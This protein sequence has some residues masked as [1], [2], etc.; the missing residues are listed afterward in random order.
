MALPLPLPRYEI[1][2]LYVED[3][4]STREQI[5]RMLEHIV[6]ELYVAG[7]GQ[8]GLEQFREHSPDVVLTDIRMPVMNG[9]DMIREIN[10]IDPDCQVI[11]LTDF[12]VTEYLLE[13]I[14]LG[15]NQFLKNPY[16]FPQLAQAIGQCND[17]I[18]LKRHLAR[19]GDLVHLLS[20]AMEQA[21]VLVMITN[22]D[23]II[24]YVNSTFVRVTGYEASE[25]IGQN[26]R[27]LKSDKNHQDVY[28]ELWRTIKIGNEWEGELANRRKNGQIYWELVKICPL[29]DSRGVVTK[30]LKVSQ[31]ITERKT[32]EESLHYLS[33]HDALT[34]L[35][36]RSYFDS[37]L[38]RLAG[39]HDYPISIVIADI[40][41]LKIINDTC[42]HEEGDRVI[43]RAAESLMAVFRS[44]DVV[45]RI[46][47]DEF[48]VLLPLTDEEMAQDIVKRIRNDGHDARQI[49]P[50]Y[51]YGLSIGVATAFEASELESAFKLADERMYLGK[52]GKKEQVMSRDSPR[53]P[54]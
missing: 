4:Q 15:I 36:N 6:A 8:E 12:C 31:D 17:S 49:K 35:F 44:N 45:S 46:G 11:I 43:R 48:A 50:E 51:V 10:K 21:P 25:V 53:A 20:Q 13:S 41:D 47:G 14:S 39:S 54:L 29:L 28:M 27:I 18:Q 9:L 52:F 33:T 3:D 38:R 19:Q 2:L 5:S 30:Y 40:D 34:G 32:Y 7:N 22:L 26:P 23:G 42:G 1:S 24:E 16:N 37:V